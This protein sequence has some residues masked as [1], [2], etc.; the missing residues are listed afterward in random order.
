MR[1]RRTWRRGKKTMRQRRCSLTLSEYVTSL[2]SLVSVSVH[3]TSNNNKWLKSFS[4]FFLCE[5]PFSCFT[6]LTWLRKKLY[7][8]RGDFLQMW[9]PFQWCEIGISECEM[10]WSR[11]NRPRTNS[12]YSWNSFWQ[13]TRAKTKV[14]TKPCFRTNTTANKIQLLQIPKQLCTNSWHSMWHCWC[15]MR[16][17]GCFSS[18]A[19]ECI[20]VTAEVVAMHT[21]QH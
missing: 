1:R 5:L 12:L 11:V 15:I 9:L 14:H 3:P 10:A 8:L 20:A 19:T 6:C 13:T 21:F 16:L 18:T 7:A 4:W 17:S 2:S